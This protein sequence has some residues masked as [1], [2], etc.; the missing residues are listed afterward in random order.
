MGIR[1]FLERAASKSSKI[2]SDLRDLIGDDKVSSSMSDLLV[3]CHD[4]SPINLHRLLRLDFDSFPLV[5]AWPEDSDDVAKIL[6]YARDNGVPVYPYGGGSGVLEAFKPLSSGIVVDLKRMNHIKLD[7]D[8]FLV[9]C[10]AGVNGMV[11]EKY[12]NTRD[13][14]LGHIP[15]SLLES[16]VGG[17]VATKATGQFS[18]KYGGIEYLIAGL[19]VVTPS[20]EVIFCKPHPRSAV[21]P[22]LKGLFIGSEG[23]FGIVTR[24]VFRVWPYPEKRAKLSFLSDSFEEA[25]YSV[26][27]ILRKG[28]FPAVIR[29]YD[30]LETLRHFYWVDGVKGRVI[31]IIISE[32]NE[33]VVDAEASVIKSTFKGRELGEEPVDHWLKTRF[34]VKEASIYAPLGFVFD[35]IEVA[36]V[37]SKV[38]KLYN[39][40]TRSIKNVNGTLFAS[41]HASHFYLQGACLYFTFGGLPPK[42]MSVYDYHRNVWKGA[43]DAVLRVGGTISHHHGIGRVRAP[44]IRDEL[45][46][47]GFLLLKRLKEI[48]DADNIM[49]PNN[50]GV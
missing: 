50:M 9:D 6:R 33:K 45:G 13:F 27:N 28:I 24:V 38:M 7:E 16:T 11:L 44:W 39:E 48:I 19:E 47:A 32:G 21:G 49:N 14:T 35:T 43:M 46:D 4:Y 22:D 29:I 17:W 23:M 1:D 5:V 8:N 12:L 31:T 41:A 2:A 10:G 25:L 20:G 15:Q 40:V 26:R 42:D 37:W 34:I 18:T 36:A 30:K 3:Y